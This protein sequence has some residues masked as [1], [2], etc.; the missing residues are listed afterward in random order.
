MVPQPQLPRMAEW[1]LKAH[2]QGL[3]GFSESRTMGAARAGSVSPPALAMP[4][5]PGWGGWGETG[6]LAAVG[7]EVRWS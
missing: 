3:G 4:T 6:Q 1:T 7:P 5:C 2:P